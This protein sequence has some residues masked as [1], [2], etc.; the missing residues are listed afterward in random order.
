MT[1]EYNGKSLQ[2]P[3]TFG[4]FIEKS[5]FKYSTY[6]LEHMI[7]PGRY[8]SDS[9]GTYCSDNIALVHATNFTDSPLALKDCVIDYISTKS[10]EIS[11]NGVTPCKTTYAE[12]LDMFGKENSSTKIIPAPGTRVE[13]K[14][15]N[16][17]KTVSNKYLH[18]VSFICHSSQLGK[19][20]SPEGVISKVEMRLTC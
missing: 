11:I 2:L 4:K 13:Y 14:A 8:N 10:S 9:I 3:A 1:I 7:D 15:Y 20:D 6:D 18:D 12:T 5:G 16:L 19:N 17:N